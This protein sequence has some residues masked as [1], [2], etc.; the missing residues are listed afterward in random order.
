M[1]V[2]NWQ[3]LLQKAKKENKLIFIDLY[4]TGCFPCE[5]MDKEV[6][7]NKI[8]S[9][10]LLKNFI[11]VKS[12]VFEEEIGD[13]LIL[14]YFVKGFPTFLILSP[15]GFLID[16]FSG[17]KDPGLLMEKL[18][19]ATLHN[20]KGVYLTGYSTQL[21]NG[22]PQ[23][24][25][26]V[27][28]REDRS[29]LDN[30]AASS[31]IKENRNIYPE[32]AAM[33]FIASS[34]PDEDLEDGFVNGYKFFEKMFGQELSLRKATEILNKRLKSGS[35]N[36]HEEFKKFLARYEPA[37]GEKD[38]PVVKHLLANNFF[39]LIKKD[40][41]GYLKF[42]ALNPVIYQNYFGAYY[43]SMVARKQLTPEREALMAEWG[44]KG[45]GGNEEFQILLTTARLLKNTGQAD[46]GR[47]VLNK[48]ISKGEKYEMDISYYKD[49]LKEF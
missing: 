16:R 23:M 22:S 42:M 21:D 41:T 49:M 46:R 17:F 24:Y 40:T 19:E 7:P 11:P 20:A 31:W 29:P 13:S 1:K 12:D 2:E 4:F 33:L 37:I 34:K 14:K 44:F 38:W 3:S 6:F 30:D 32:A 18:E 39:N 8:V 45:I 9:S 26:D 48:I 28:N 10:A 35:V 5:Q 43:N 36:T 25:K 15:E 47:E 27:F